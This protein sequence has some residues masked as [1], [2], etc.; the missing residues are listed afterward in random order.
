MRWQKAKI[1]YSKTLSSF[2]GGFRCRWLACLVFLS[3]YLVRFPF[4]FFPLVFLF[5]FG[6][7]LFGCGGGCWMSFA[8]HS[9]KTLCIM[10]FSCCLCLLLLNIY[11]VRFICLY[12][13]ALRNFR[14]FE[15]VINDFLISCPYRQNKSVYER[16]NVFLALLPYPCAVASLLCNDDK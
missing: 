10:F 3:A 4:R 9:K 7:P 16:L 6:L 8:L 15:R 13:A 14:E 11:C 1:R 5:R 12:T 2:V